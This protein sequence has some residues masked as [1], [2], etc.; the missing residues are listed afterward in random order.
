MNRFTCR[1]TA[2]HVAAM[3]G[4]CDLVSYFISKGAIVDQKDLLSGHTPLH[5]AC[6]AQQ[7]ETA[8]LLIEENAVG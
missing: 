7:M 2:L 6:E 1:G 5:F 4:H 8:R 3:E